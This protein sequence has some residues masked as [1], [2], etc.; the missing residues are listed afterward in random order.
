MLLSPIN[1]LSFAG[2]GR[3][4]DSWFYLWFSQLIV[5][6]E[7]TWEK[8]WQQDSLA[9]RRTHY[10]CYRG[11]LNSGPSLFQLQH[12]PRRADCLHLFTLW[13]K[14]GY[15]TVICIPASVKMTSPSW[16][17]QEKTKYKKR[18]QGTSS[19]CMQM[20]WNILVGSSSL[21]T[22]QIYHNWIGVGCC[23]SLPPPKI[24]R[25]DTCP[26]WCVCESCLRTP[27]QYASAQGIRKW[28][29]KQDGKIQWRWG[30]CHWCNS[31]P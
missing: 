19:T 23:L 16:S 15:E 22:P 8:G 7:Q 13:E 4:W 26:P 17:F 10:S 28:H 11:T 27:S 24:L 5:T 12:S 9:V 6:W 30:I 1:Y 18:V 31:L 3:L 2:L 14:R 25:Q 21:L 29:E 20:K